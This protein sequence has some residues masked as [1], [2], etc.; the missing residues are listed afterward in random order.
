MAIVTCE[1]LQGRWQCLLL[2]GWISTDWNYVTSECIPFS[3]H[4]QYSYR[5]Q[6]K[7]RVMFQ[8]VAPLIFV[9]SVWMWS[10]NQ[11]HLVWLGMVGAVEALTQSDSDLQIQHNRLYTIW[12]TVNRL[13]FRSYIRIFF[14]KCKACVLEILIKKLIMVS[15][16]SIKDQS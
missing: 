6:K 12:L 10:L 13:F 2:R 7:I 8:N 15:P 16:Q 9:W 3:W 14:W 11:W 5:E 4:W 1:Y